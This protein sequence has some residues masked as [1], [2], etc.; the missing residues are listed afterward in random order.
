MASLY[1]C[2]RNCQYIDLIAQ[3]LVMFF[4]MLCK[5][6]KIAEN[7]LSILYL[8]FKH[9]NDSLDAEKYTVEHDVVNEWDTA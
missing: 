4:V 5:K 3:M 6:L 9:N 8:V 1:I 2:N 7:G